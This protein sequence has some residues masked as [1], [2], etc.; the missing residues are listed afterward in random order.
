VVAK[1]HPLGCAVEAEMSAPPGIDGDLSTAPEELHLTDPAHA[2]AFVEETGVDCLAVNVGQAH[3]HGR[4]KV[5]LRLDLVEDLRREVPVPLVLH[6]ASS[7]ERA[8]LAAAIRLGVRKINVGSVLKQ[9]FL[10]A[11]REGC[12]A[13]PPDANPYE[14]L[15]SGFQQDLLTRG[16]VAEREVVEELLHLFGSAGKA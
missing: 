16:R 9:R 11:L 7:I 5:H 3:L 6:G 1:A 2:R 15:G 10:S 12:A 8:D 14:A 4:E 13:V